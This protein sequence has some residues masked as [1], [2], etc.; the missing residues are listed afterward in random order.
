MKK[1]GDFE[2]YSKIEKLLELKHE[3]SKNLHLLLLHFAKI[4]QYLLE[5]LL[6]EENFFNVSLTIGEGISIMLPFYKIKI[7]A[8][9][10][11][12]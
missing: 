8:F 7:A 9:L 12:K 10:R 5:M 6:L 2:D 11:I 3:N 1:F 4:M